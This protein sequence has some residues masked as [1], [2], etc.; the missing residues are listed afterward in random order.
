M[1]R[2]PCEGCSACQLNTTL[3]R[4]LCL[5]QLLTHNITCGP[6]REA[7]I[8][9]R[10]CSNLIFSDGNMYPKSAP[11]VSYYNVILSD[12]FLTISSVFLALLLIGSLF[13]LCVFL[14]RNCRQGGPGV[15]GEVYNYEK[16][17]QVDSQDESSDCEIYFDMTKR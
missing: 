8:Y 12:V 5:S 13:Y 7:F 17:L 1:S 15:R 11:K 14:R 9:I 2:P 16:I 3:C 10:S 4:L 6:D